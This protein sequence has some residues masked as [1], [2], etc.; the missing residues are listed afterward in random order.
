MPSID[1]NTAT[2]EELAEVNGIGE[3]LAAAIVDAAGPGLT[4]PDAPPE[5]P[6]RLGEPRSP[7]GQPACLVRGEPV[8][9]DCPPS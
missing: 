7:D 2:R 5:R 1:I 9:A 4:G 6:R 3:I 8:V